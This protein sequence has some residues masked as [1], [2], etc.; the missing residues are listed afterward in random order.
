APFI[1][2]IGDVE[3]IVLWPG[4]AH[5]AVRVDNHFAHEIAFASPREST[6]AQDG[7]TARTAPPPASS[8][9]FAAKASETRSSRINARPRPFAVEPR[10]PICFSP[11]IIGRPELGA[12]S[13]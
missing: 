13:S 3:R 11:A 5:E 8:V 4:A 10:V 7:F 9:V 12:N 1:V 6:F 2:V